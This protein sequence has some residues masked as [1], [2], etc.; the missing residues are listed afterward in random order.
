[1]VRDE[2]EIKNEDDIFEAMKYTELLAYQQSFN[3]NE[4]MKLQL[5]TEEACTN[6]YEYSV[7]H[8][9]QSF[10]IQWLVTPEFFEMVIVQ[11]GQVFPLVQRD[12]VNK[13]LRGRGIT[14]I[15]NLM[16]VV[17][18]RENN[19]FVELYMRKERVCSI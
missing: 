12:E 18:V 11:E 2:R 19:N 16:D 8:G 15:L 7:K 14:L 5:V 13:G 17:E 3:I 10:K 1:M 9:K 6:A 4:I